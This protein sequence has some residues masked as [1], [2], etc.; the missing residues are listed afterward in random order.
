MAKIQCIKRSNGTLAY[1]AYLPKEEL[2]K[3]GLSK[4]EEV[5][6]R[7]NRPGSLEIFNSSKLHNIE[8]LPAE[9]SNQIVQIDFSKQEVD[10]FMPLFDKPV[11]QQKEMAAK[12]SLWI[13]R[14][15]DEESKTGQLSDSLRRWMTLYKEILDSIHKNLYGEKSLR[16]NFRSEISHA[17]IAALMRKYRNVPANKESN[18]SVGNANLS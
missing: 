15:M 3:A 8:I 10:N 14:Q 11:Q 2:D 9:T 6:I 12:L 17:D 16:M 7:S 1:S 4:G 13:T 18:V 5:I